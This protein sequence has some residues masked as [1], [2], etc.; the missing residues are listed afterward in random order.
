M[1]GLETVAAVVSLGTGILG[2]LQQAAAQNE[3]ARARVAQIRRARE[4]EEARRRDLLRREQA[5]RRARFGA[6]GIAGTGGSADAVLRGL[7]LDSAR[8][9]AE[10]ASLDRLRTG[11]IRARAAARNR[12][13][14][15][16]TTDS[17]FGGL[18]RL[19]K[20]GAFD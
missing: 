11:D 6:A 18:A 1:S 10:D 2:G 14:L 12:I 17:F 8:R 16:E 5:T 19:E 4:I 13:N 9:G 7:A 20:L 3:A 15:L